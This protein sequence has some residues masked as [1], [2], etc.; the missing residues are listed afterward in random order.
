[1]QDDAAPLT[2][3][4]GF[5]LMGVTCVVMQHFEA[6]AALKKLIGSFNRGTVEPLKGKKVE[7]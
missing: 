5:L 7:G 3:T 6:E 1:M 2:F 4:M